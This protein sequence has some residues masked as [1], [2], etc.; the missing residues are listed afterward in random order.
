MPPLGTE[1]KNKGDRIVTS[2]EVGTNRAEC[3]FKEAKGS[4]HSRKKGGRGQL[5]QML[6]RFCSTESIECGN[7]ELSTGVKRKEL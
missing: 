5:S 6:L 1:T 7:V 4:P 2:R 3:S